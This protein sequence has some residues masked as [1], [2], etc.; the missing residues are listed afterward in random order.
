MTVETGL[1]GLDHAR[2]GLDT[3]WALVDDSRRLGL[4]DERGA[5][6]RQGRNP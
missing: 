6:R 1:G 2:S 3:Q 5:L 4:G